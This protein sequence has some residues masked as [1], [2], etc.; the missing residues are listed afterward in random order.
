[1]EGRR[2]DSELKSVQLSR[3]GE[4]GRNRRRNPKGREGEISEAWKTKSVKTEILQSEDI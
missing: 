2:K 3:F 1:M 4:A